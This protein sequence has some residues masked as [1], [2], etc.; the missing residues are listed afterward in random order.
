MTYAM[1]KRLAPSKQRKTPPI[2]GGPVTGYKSYGAYGA[3]KK[4]FTATMKKKLKG[5]PVK[6][7]PKPKKIVKTTKK[8][9][10]SDEQ[11]YKKHKKIYKDVEEALKSKFRP[12]GPKIQD[13]DDDEWDDDNNEP[14]DA[15][16]HIPQFIK[17]ML[18][19]VWNQLKIQGEFSKESMATL[20]NLHRI[21][22]N[23]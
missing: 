20:N 10:V 21:A 7:T 14:E 2:P 1:R 9:A 13:P 22:S 17:S 3:K 11:K 19:T 6:K 4:V 5:L 8:I 18:S 16:Q 12:G 23:Q 15:K